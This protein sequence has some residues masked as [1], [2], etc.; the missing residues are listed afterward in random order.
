MSKS[1]DD[2]A[3]E[4]LGNSFRFG[5]DVQLRVDVLHV[6]TDCIDT[7]AQLGRRGLVVVALGE[8]PQQ[9]QFVRGQI[10]SGWFPRPDFAKKLDHSPCHLWRHRSAA[11]GR[12]FQ[13][14]KQTG[15]RCL[16]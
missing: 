7:D 9:A 8:K 3:T 1:V 4:G 13:T 5:M 6:K 14:L 2:A 16:L 10:V 11:V 15:W 12:L